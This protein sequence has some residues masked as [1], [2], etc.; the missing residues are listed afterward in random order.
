MCVIPKRVCLAVN[1]HRRHGSNRERRSTIQ[2]RA[3]SPQHDNTTED[4]HTGRVTGH[5]IALA[6]KPDVVSEE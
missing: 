6:P 5:Q 1:T 3:V 2:E 4:E